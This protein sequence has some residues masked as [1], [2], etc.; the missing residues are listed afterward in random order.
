MAKKSDHLWNLERCAICRKKVEVS[1]FLELQQSRSR[2]PDHQDHHVEVSQGHLQSVFDAEDSYDFWDAKNQEGA[3]LVR[4][5]W[6]SCSPSTRQGLSRE[7]PIAI[8][9]FHQNNVQATSVLESPLPSSLDFPG[10]LLLTNLHEPILCSPSGM[11]FSRDIS[12]YF[13]FQFWKSIQ[14]GCL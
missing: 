8:G 2:R 1:L 10:V 7:T 9:R 6:D 11:T 14:M 4:K 5:V 3:S 12:R 13:L